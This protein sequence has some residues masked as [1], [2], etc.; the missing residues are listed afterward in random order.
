MEWVELITNIGF[1]IACC[2][3]LFQQNGKLADALSDLNK[4]LSTID[5]R[6]ERLEREVEDNANKA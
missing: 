1:P 6:L 2:V 3:F 4:T 5:I